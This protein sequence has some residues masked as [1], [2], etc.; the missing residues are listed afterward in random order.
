MPNMT[1]IIS[2]NYSS[3]CCGALTHDRG[4]GAMPFGG[5]YRLIDFP[6]SNMV[7]SGIIDL[8]LIAPMNFR[9]L[10]DHVG[11]G[12]EWALSRKTGG[13][14]ILPGSPFGLKNLKGR[15]L[16]K[17]ITKN[18]DV[19]ERLPNDYIALCAT[20]KVFN[21]DYREI[22]EFHLNHNADITLVYKDELLRLGPKDYS[23][24]EDEGQR[25]IS[26]SNSS[27]D[28]SNCFLDTL[29]INK[30]TIEKI[31]YEYRSHEYMDLI[32]L[33]SK[34]LSV[35]NV[36]SYNFKG[37][38]SSFNSIKGYLNANQDLLDYKINEEI[39]SKARP[40][41]T[42][43]HDNPPP[44]YTSVST[45]KNSIISTGCIIKGTVDNSIIFRGVIIMEG[46]VVKNSV[47]LQNSII[48]EN[49][50]LNYVVM[51]KQ[52]KIN[53]N[54]KIEGTSENPIII[55]KDH[56]YRKDRGYNVKSNKGR[57]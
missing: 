24:I 30:V 57:P 34:N 37:Y 21:I 29:I 2:T 23:I 11:I 49:A 16:I 15:F 36:F 55:D 42:K 51:D 5:R 27:K 28:K 19:L 31:V 39:F 20:S 18:K 9:A 41:I 54:E 38:T 3:D 14:Y 26:I 7:N 46:S 8:G 48:G 50:N 17:D 43:T 40:I 47:V 22:L 44:K 32:E 6:L 53:D 10:L 33:I 25:V 13:L 52:T 1:G 56:K 12:K 45:V 4:I 35:F